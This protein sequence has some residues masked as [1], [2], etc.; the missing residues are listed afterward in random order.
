MRRH[1]SCNYR[2]IRLLTGGEYAPVPVV[3]RLGGS[4]HFDEEAKGRS[5]LH[6]GGNTS[7]Q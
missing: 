7:A 1:V 4:R 3:L 2:L 5:H 6:R